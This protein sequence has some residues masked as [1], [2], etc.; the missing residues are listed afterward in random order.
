[1]NSLQ[2][3]INIL[4]RT[5]QHPKLTLTECR[6]L[7]LIANGHTTAGEMSKVANVDKAQ[8]NKVG[9]DLVAK[10]YLKIS[11]VVAREYHYKLSNSGLEELKHILSTQ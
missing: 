10:G 2:F 11:K 7:L 3:A 1:M 8:Y 4:Q 5:T 6:A 9:K